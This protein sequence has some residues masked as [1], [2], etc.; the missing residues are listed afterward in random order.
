MEKHFGNF[1]SFKYPEM[2][3]NKAMLYLK[4]VSEMK[5]NSDGMFLDGFSNL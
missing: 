1:H 5:R 4:C 3:L 2:G